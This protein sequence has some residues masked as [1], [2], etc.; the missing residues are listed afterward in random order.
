M[1]ISVNKKVKYILVLFML[2]NFFIVKIKYKQWIRY[3][4]VERK[5]HL[6]VK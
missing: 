5:G 4:D 6:S 2:D 3:F 1:Y